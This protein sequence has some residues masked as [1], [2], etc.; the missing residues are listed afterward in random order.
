[1]T[2]ENSPIFVNIVY[3]L[4]Q[5]EKILADF[6]VWRRE[7][8][9]DR[10]TFVNEVNTITKN[11]E[12]FAETVDSLRRTLLGFAFTIAGSAVVFALTVLIATGKLGG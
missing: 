1:M 5:Y 11:Q 8:D 2:P 6:S 7:V 4:D 9:R 3:R 12:T 10:T